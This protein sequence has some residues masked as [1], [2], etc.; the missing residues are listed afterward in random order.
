MR[1]SVLG[2]VVRCVSGCHVEE[3]ATEH[4]LLGAMAVGE[5]AV[6]ADA[7]EAV[8]ERVPGA[9]AGSV[10]TRKRRM[11]SSASSVMTLERPWWR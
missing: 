4:E 1:G 2:L 8:R 3:P 9:C 10:C 6:M 5:E 7:M 11:N